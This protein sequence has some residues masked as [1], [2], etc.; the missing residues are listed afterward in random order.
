FGAL[1]FGV[2]RALRFTFLPCTTL[3]RSHLLQVT[4]RALEI[5]E[6]FGGLHGAGSHVVGLGAVLP[7]DAGHRVDA[8]AQARERLILLSRG[9]GDASRVGGRFRGR[10]DDGVQGFERGGRQLLDVTDVHLAAAHLLH[11]FAYL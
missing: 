10:D 3:F 11:D 2:R 4:R 9:G 5:G 1:F 8:L 6:P 7:G